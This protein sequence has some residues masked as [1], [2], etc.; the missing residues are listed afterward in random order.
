MKLF[1]KSKVSAKQVVDPG[2]SPAHTP[3]TLFCIFKVCVG[4]SE[5]IKGTFSIPSQR[6]VY[7]DLNASSRPLH[8]PPR[9]LGQSTCVSFQCLQE[10]GELL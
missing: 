10:E 7:R 2:A 5:F 4:G 1:P 3:P 9:L 8:P 6:E